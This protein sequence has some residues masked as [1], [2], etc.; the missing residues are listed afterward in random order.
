M[1]GH[2]VLMS[3]MPLRAGHY[4][5]VFT[6]SLGQLTG[7]ALATTVGVVIPLMLIVG[8]PELSASMQGLVGAAD[9]I[10]IAAGSAVLGPIA[11]RRGYLAMFR[12]CPVLIMLAAAVAALVPSLPVLLVC[13]F[14]MGFG[15][16]GEYTLDSGYVSEIMPVKWRSTMVGV[17]K[18]ASAAGNIIAAWLCF[19]VLSGGLEASHWPRLMWIIA[20]IAAFMALTR[21][22]FVQSPLWL[23]KHGHTA[24]AEAA[25]EKLLGPDVRVATAAQPA[26][27]ATPRSSAGTLAFMRDNAARVVLSG[28]PWACEGLG[29]YGIGVF[30]PV[31]VAALGLEHFTPQMAPAAH[32]TKSVEIT[33]WISCIMLPGFIAGLLLLRRAGKVSL[34]AWGFFLSAVSLALLMAAYEFR[35]P[36]W[37]AI[38]AFM[39]FELFL[40][41][42]PHLVTYIMPAAI[43]PVADRARGAGIAACV[44][45]IG[46]VLGVFFMP[47][48][49]HAGGMRLVLAVSIGV[50]LLGG[51]VTAS[52]GRIVCR[53]RAAGVRAS[54]QEA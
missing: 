9:L 49:L 2:T 52:A 34:Q 43:Y 39:A 35:W 6:A 24:Q 53:R 46:A 21:V 42:G 19:M 41:M 27:P 37:T 47:V 38:G 36:S 48:L 33:L 28:L 54:K 3:T 10:G 15:I 16:G 17:T 23:L 13:L 31:L 44:G 5:T 20:G 8:R 30:L 22:G 26:A 18:A 45:K 7:T 50:M 51:F 29:V 11:D 1:E 25:A 32:V 12:A 4:R 40:N 14:V